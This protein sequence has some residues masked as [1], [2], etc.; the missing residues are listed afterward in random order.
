MPDGALQIKTGAPSTAGAAGHPT[1]VEAAPIR[2]DRASLQGFV[3]DADSEAALRA[4]LGDLL[5][6][7][8]DIRRGG[9]RAAYATMQ[10]SSTPKILVVDVSGEDQPLKALGQKYFRVATI[11]GVMLMCSNG[12]DSGAAGAGS[13]RDRIAM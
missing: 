2:H 11:D 3:T 8:P 10:K 12:S 4:G 6:E 5:P 7:V 13:S 9:I 1:V